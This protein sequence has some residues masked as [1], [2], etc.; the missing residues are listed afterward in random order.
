MNHWLI[1]SEPD[2]YSFDDLEMDKKTEWTGVR[3]YA[4]RIH[5]NNMKKG[6]ICLYYHS[7]T[8]KTIV[9]LCKVSQE[10][11]PDPTDE[12]GKWVA[13]EVAFL[14]KLNKPV[15]YSDLKALNHMKNFDLIR[16]SRLSVMPVP[17][18]YWYEILEMAETSVE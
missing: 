8:E 6:D 10:A 1:K 7:V 9:G 3:N 11:Y 14:K 12:T 5:L 15:L 13:V 18:E 4:A 2:E 17:D 16:I